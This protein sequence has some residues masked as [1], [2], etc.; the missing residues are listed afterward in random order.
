M[1]ISVLTLFIF[2]IVEGFIYLG[3]CLYVLIWRD[4]HRSKKAWRAM[5]PLERYFIKLGLFFS[6]FLPAFKL[7]GSFD[8]Y[9]GQVVIGVMSTIASGLFIVGLIA[10]MKQRHSIRVHLVNPKKHTSQL[11][12]IKQRQ[13]T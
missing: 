5:S 7:S 10:Y 11:D 12:K 3:Y 2:L 4:R 6:V 9:I 13:S 1:G 8:F